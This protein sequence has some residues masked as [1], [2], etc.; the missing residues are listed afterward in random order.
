MVFRPVLGIDGS[1]VGRRRRN[2]SVVELKKHF[3]PDFYHCLPF[4]H[5]NFPIKTSL[6]PSLE[7]PVKTQILI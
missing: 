5:Q 4:Q 1:G 7:D 3:S 6:L 2:C